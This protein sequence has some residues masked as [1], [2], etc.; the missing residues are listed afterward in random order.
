MCGKLGHKLSDRR[1]FTLIELMIVII[2]VGI[3]A[4]VAIPMY[5][6]ST[7]RAR[8]SEAESALGT[9]RSALRVFY[10][11]YGRYPIATTSVDVTTLT[12]SLD[13]DSD[14]LL[15]RYFDQDDYTYQS[16]ADGDSFTVT[17]IGARGTKTAPEADKVSGITRTIDQDGNI[18]R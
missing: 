2:I 10:A 7:Q 6:G 8:A 13:L 17:A 3:L 15:G 18:G 16:T 4:A 5:R 14:D 9:I 12:D 1:G 11:E